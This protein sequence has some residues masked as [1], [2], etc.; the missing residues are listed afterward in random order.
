[1][2]LNI[3]IMLSE[4]GSHPDQN[5]FLKKDSGFQMPEPVFRSSEGKT[6]IP[7]SQ[8][9]AVRAEQQTERQENEKDL[10]PWTLQRLDFADSLDQAESILKDY[11]ETRHA[12]NMNARV[13]AEVVKQIEIGGKLYNVFKSLNPDAQLSILPDYNADRTSVEQVWHTVH[14]DEMLFQI[15]GYMTTGRLLMPQQLKERIT[16]EHIKQFYKEFPTEDKYMQNERIGMMLN[17]LKHSENM[18]LYHNYHAKAAEF[19]D[20]MYPED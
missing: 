15:L 19:V 6:V 7:Y 11:N 13:N 18:R 12:A 3:V 16:I 2:Q 14:Q 4:G 9:G 17:G 8:K 20:I 1:M 5:E 10:L